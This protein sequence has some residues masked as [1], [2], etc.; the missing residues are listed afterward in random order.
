M[1]NIILED[2]KFN[3]E[4]YNIFDD[5]RF[6]SLTETIYQQLL[7]ILQPRQG[8]VDDPHIKDCL[9]C[10][11]LLTFHCPPRL[12]QYLSAYLETVIK[13]ILILS[14][15][16]PLSLDLLQLCLEGANEIVATKF[17]LLSKELL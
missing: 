8:L 10:I 15:S 12:Y 13:P 16:H 7:T 9:K 11:N 3:N 14:S 5:Q 17:S 1:V 6:W 2:I 4:N